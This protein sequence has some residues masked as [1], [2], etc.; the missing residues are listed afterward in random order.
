VSI[1][2]AIVV[3]VTAAIALSVLVQKNWPAILHGA[4]WAGLIGQWLINRKDSKD[5]REEETEATNGVDAIPDEALAV[6]GALTSAGGTGYLAN[7]IRPNL[8][9]RVHKPKSVGD[10]VRLAQESINLD[11]GT[12]LNEKVANFVRSETDV[13]VAHSAT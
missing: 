6:S 2:G 7:I 5:R 1:G 10:L 13:N 4:A 8:Q 12:R 3:F 9:T 11:V